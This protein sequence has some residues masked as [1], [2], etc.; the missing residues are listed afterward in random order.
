MR[1][2]AL[3][4]Q[5]HGAILAKDAKA[6]V[7]LLKAN[8]RIA[9]EAQMAIYIEG[10]RAR[11]V[12][13]IRGDYPETAALLGEQ[14]FEAL[15]LAYVEDAPP[16]HVSLDVYPFGF[17]DFVVAR[18]GGF[19]GSVALLEA[20]IARVFLLPD[21]EPLNAG[22]LAG[23]T[24]EGFGDL[25]LRLREAS[26]LLGLDFAAEAYISARRRGEEIMVPEAAFSPVMVVRHGNEVRRHVLHPVGYGLLQGL[27]GG[28]CMDEALEQAA[29][30][31]GALVVLSQHLQAWFA[32]WVAEGF[33][34]SVGG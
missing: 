10:Y 34:Q 31:E 14:D 15:A 24:P 6:V 21:S 9:P 29:G 28:L 27:A 12:G 5:F 11:L 17:G 4:A 18:Q 22:I 16:V 23:M 7:P 1:L 13:A 25:R 20:A 33:F 26:V 3:L 19:A 30:T 2:E 32:L 8:G